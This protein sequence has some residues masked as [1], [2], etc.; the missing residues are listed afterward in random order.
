MNDEIEFEM[1]EILINHKQAKKDSDWKT[2]NDLKERFFYL[3]GIS[4][5]IE[6]SDVY[7]FDN[8]V[9]IWNNN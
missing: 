5:G 3:G 4:R 6:M 2:C 7:Q 9:K 1:Q 8:L